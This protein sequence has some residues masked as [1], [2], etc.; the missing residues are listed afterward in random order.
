MNRILPE[1]DSAPEAAVAEPPP[2]KPSSRLHRLVVWLPGLLALIALAFVLLQFG[3]LKQLYRLIDNVRLPWLALGVVA[4]L[5]TYAAAAAVWYVVLRR[6]AHRRHLAGLYL[7]G[8]AKLF[9]DQALPSGGVS[10]S[11]LVVAA[12]RRRGVSAHIA[13]AALLIGMLSF[14]LAF[15]TAAGA[16]LII[17]ALEHALN[18]A[19]VLVVIVFLFIAIAL[20][21]AIFWLR[22]RKGSRFEAWLRYLPLGHQFW[23]AIHDAPSV[24]LRDVTLLVSTTLLQILII[25][26]DAATL[27]IVLAALGT[28][29]PFGMC[30]AAF[31]L[32]SIIADVAPIPLGLGSFEAALVS[33]LSI[34]GSG[35]EV[36]FAATILLRGLTFWAPM[37]PG[38]WIARWEIR[39]AAALKAARTKGSRSKAPQA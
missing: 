10:G 33:L 19:I 22:R 29:A 23:S 27:W 12:L 17:M 32:A 5:C 1:K 13:T 31:T 25:A 21:F 35:L 38:L 14:Y 28:R 37:L 8:V 7:L 15:L 2:A 3:E 36:A 4:Q 16:S 34:T 6:A 11:V 20:I 30:F 9:M 26:L 39:G 18:S 24:L